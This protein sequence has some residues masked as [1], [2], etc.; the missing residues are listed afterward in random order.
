MLVRLFV[1]SALSL[2]LFLP[3]TR[4]SAL[5]VAQFSAICEAAPAECS[6][7]PTLQAYVGGALDLLATL[8]Q[9]TEYLG[10]VYCKHPKGLFDVPKIIRYMET[11]QETHKQSSANRNAM[12]LLVRY[13]EENGGC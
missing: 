3:A 8:D 11:H 4:A 13:F 12:L 7:H 9:D 5:T 6:E 10:K 1:V 2:S